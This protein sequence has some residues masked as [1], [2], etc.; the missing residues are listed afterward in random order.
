MTRNTLVWAVAAVIGT[1]GAADANG[2]RRATA[3]VPPTQEIEI[4]DPNVDPTGK[5]TVVLRPGP[6]GTQIVDIPPAVL[7]HRFYYTGDRSFQAQLLPGGPTIVAVN[8]PK[9]MERVY[10][11][12]TLPPGAPRVHYTPS[13]IRYDFGPQSVTL[14]FNTC[15][16]VP[17]VH[18]SQATALGHRV[19]TAATNAAAGA[20]D[21]VQRTGL[22]SGVQ[23]LAGGAKEAAGGAA[24]RV[25]DL[26]RAIALPITKAVMALPGAQLLGGSPEDRATREQ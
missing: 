18:Y 3:P 4:L 10:V 14:S 6:A 22:P 21:L 5:P 9:T 16:G 23:Q 13:T 8:H 11:Q 7:V 15:G 2:V 25:N 1:G 24:D 12:V 19:H 20:R 17:S 26:G